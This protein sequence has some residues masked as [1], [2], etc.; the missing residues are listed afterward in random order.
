[1]SSVITAPKTGPLTG[2]LTFPDEEAPRSVTAMSVLDKGDVLALSDTL[3]RLRSHRHGAGLAV[4][5]RMLLRCLNSQER[6]YVAYSMGSA[7]SV[8]VGSSAASEMED[9]IQGMTPDVGV[10]SE[11]VVRQAQRNAAARAGLLQEFGALTGEQIGEEHSSARN[12]HALAA[13]WRKEGRIFG[14]PHHGRTVFPAFQFDPTS[15]ELR[16]AIR[17]VLT[18]LPTERLSDWEVALWWAAANGWLGGRRPVDLID[19]EPEAITIA[20]ARLAG[21]SPL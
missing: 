5:L 9:L 2:P 14:V 6:V 3:S 16:P 18:A 15:G 19:D 12:R 10:P 11:S 13:R 21:P 1:M 8:R 17:R 7:G 20:A 4:H